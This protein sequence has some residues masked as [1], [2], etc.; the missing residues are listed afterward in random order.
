MCFASDYD[1]YAEF[2][3]NSTPIAD[4]D[5]RCDECHCAI[6]AGT[7]YHH[8]YM[9]QHEECR[10]CD[11]GEC[12]C[13][14]IFEDGVQVG[15]TCED[16]GCQCAEPNIGE[17]FEWHCCESC[18]K[19]LDAIEAAEVEAGCKRYEARPPLTEMLDSLRNAG[20]RDCKRY[21]RKA[22]QMFP[23]LVI[24]DYLPKLWRKL[25]AWE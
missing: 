21:Y 24:S 6:P 23:E 12:E 3:D 18:F 4:R 16:N 2:I 8:T 7:R 10:D 22:S 19:F 15:R 14:P 25:F 11:N 9:Q 17:T 13:Q 20:A 5:I 1:W